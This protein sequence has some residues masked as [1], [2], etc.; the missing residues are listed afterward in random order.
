MEWGKTNAML[1]LREVSMGSG[2]GEGDISIVKL[3]LFFSFYLFLFF[4]YLLCLFTFSVK[5][6]INFFGENFE[7]E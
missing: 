7:F 3:G 1:E 5:I 4:S 2:C 6:G